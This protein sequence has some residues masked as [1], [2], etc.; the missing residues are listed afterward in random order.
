MSA[1]QPLAATRHYTLF[2]PIQGTPGG[3][4]NAARSASCTALLGAAAG[5]DC[6]R[7]LVSQS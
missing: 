2:F 1:W 5:L 4:P 3:D 7:P 6:G